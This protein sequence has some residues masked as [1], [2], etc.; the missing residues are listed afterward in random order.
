MAG[1]PI[2]LAC[3]PANPNSLIS[4]MQSFQTLVISLKDSLVRQQTVSRELAKTKLQWKF[5]DAVDGRK[6]DLS[7]VPY[8][9]NKVKRL[10]GFELM[11]SEI[12]C[13]LS[14]MKAWQS[15][16]DSQITTL[17]FED[18]FVVSENFDELLET[19]LLQALNWDIIRLQG[20]SECEDVFLQKIGSYRLA[21]NTSDPL[22][23]T[24]YIVRPTAARQLLLH[25]LEIFEPVDHF[26]EHVEKHGLIVT[27][28]K[29]YPVTVVDTTRETTT[30]TDRPERESIRGVQKKIR[31]IARAWDRIS[32][33][34]PYF[35]K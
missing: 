26:L 10:L 20:L 31:S 1:T 27:A 2:W 8:N 24:A 14:H 7:S 5:L 28:M 22:G 30:I 32:S 25:S 13:Y 19:M 4:T 12:G 9:S 34:N 15:C 35:P 17:I 3:K 29:P 11:P 23:S 21:R 6:L 33:N 16:V 18:D